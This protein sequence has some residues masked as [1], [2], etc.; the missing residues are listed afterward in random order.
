MKEKRSSRFR[1]EPECGKTPL[2]RIILQKL[3]LSDV[4]Q[5]IFVNVPS[6]FFQKIRDSY[7]NISYLVPDNFWRSAVLYG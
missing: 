2:A 7:G 5:G 6:N 4:L 3:M 1:G